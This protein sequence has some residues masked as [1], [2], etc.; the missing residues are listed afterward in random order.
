MTYAFYILQN[1]P[2][3]L[4]K[5]QQR[6]QY[7]MVDEFQDVSAM[8]YEMAELLSGYHKNLFIVGDPDQTIYT[9][10]G[11]RIE[12]ILNFDKVHRGCTDIIM[13]KNR[14]D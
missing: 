13:D 10:R 3:K 2:E 5:W 9:W 8:Q 14:F 1:F 12:F 4:H 11:A 6:L 7:V